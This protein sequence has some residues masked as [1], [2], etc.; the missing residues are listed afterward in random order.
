MVRSLSSSHPGPPW[1]SLDGKRIAGSSLAICVHVVVLGALMFPNTWSPPAK[2][3]RPETIPVVFEPVPPRDIQPTQAPPKAQPVPQVR[4]SP[5]Q[6][7]VQTTPV[8]VVENVP[9]FEQGQI[10]APP[11]ADSSQQSTDFD[12]GPPVLSTLAYDVAPAPRYPRASVIAGHEGT[13][14]LRVLVDETGQPQEAVVE[15]S[16]GHRALDQAARTQVLQRWRFHPARQ[17][18]RAVA[19]YALVPIEFRLP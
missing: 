17:Q 2:P 18:G 7:V 6:P 15:R 10:E 13:V 8:P 16:S 12:P 4:P 5:V 14:T 19:A 1:Q 9:V 11:V 3:V